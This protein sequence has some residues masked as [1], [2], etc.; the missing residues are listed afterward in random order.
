MSGEDKIVTESFV[1]EIQT[2]P[3]HRDLSDQIGFKHCPVFHVAQCALN[4]EARQ[5]RRIQRDTA[6]A[7]YAG[8]LGK[9]R[10]LVALASCLGKSFAESDLFLHN[11]AKI[12]Q[13]ESFRFL[14]TCRSIGLHSLASEKVS[15]KNEP[16][17]LSRIPKPLQ[18]IV[19][20]RLQDGIVRIGDC[21]GP[22]LSRERGAEQKHVD[23]GIE[24]ALLETRTDSVILALSPSLPLRLIWLF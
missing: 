5:N 20:P 11:A 16:L 18:K 21:G 9:I 3:D 2:G 10:R 6:I 19:Q 22:R 4:P 17:V 8:P 14:V 13:H 12:L 15:Q 24:P 7:K 1:G 23:H